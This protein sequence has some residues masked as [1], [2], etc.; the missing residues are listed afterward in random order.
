[1]QD[2]T[3]DSG[4][5]HEMSPFVVVAQKEECKL[6]NQPSE[7]SSEESFHFSLTKNKDNKLAATSKR[8]MKASASNLQ[9]E[10]ETP[11]KLNSISRLSNLAMAQLNKQPGAGK[12]RILGDKLQL[13]KHKSAQQ[14]LL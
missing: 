10:D 3:E 1:M 8:E 13:S 14:E 4:L 11:T 12:S 5:A 7:N 9:S 6:E 2:K